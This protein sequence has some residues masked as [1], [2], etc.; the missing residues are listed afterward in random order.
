M[1]TAC[2]QSPT[3]THSLLRRSVQHWRCAGTA[4]VYPCPLA[5]PTRQTAQHRP[6]AWGQHCQ[7]LPVAAQGYQGALKTALAKRF[8]PRKRNNLQT[9]ST[10]TRALKGGE[11]FLGR[12]QKWKPHTYKS[13]LSHYCMR[14]PCLIMRVDNTPL[15]GIWAS[16][17]YCPLQ[18]PLQPFLRC[19]FSQPGAQNELF[20]MGHHVWQWRMVQ[21]G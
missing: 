3:H 13:P 14:F 15:L 5:E 2:I 7:G 12:P 8:Q 6:A 11:A 19:S 21:P 16:K 20:Q 18:W 4:H 9:H 1:I 10:C 17:A